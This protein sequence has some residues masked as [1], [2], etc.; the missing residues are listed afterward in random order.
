MPKAF[1]FDI[2][3]VIIAFD[4]ARTVS[5]LADQC[6]VGADEA[7]AK[8]GALT[9]ELE[10]GRILPEDFVSLASETIGYAG[11][12][13]FFRSAFEDIFEL[14]RPIVEFIEA[15]KAGDAEL[16]LLSN[17]NGIHAPFFEKTYPVFELFD[18]RIYSHEV[19]A[20]KPDARIYDIAIERLGLSPE[21]T[22]YVDDLP[23]NCEAGRRAG[24]ATI[25]YDMANHAG[26]LEAFERLG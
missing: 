14:N 12:P 24:F 5:K 6:A 21:S 16:H 2:G 10:L 8:V 11:E 4:F 26:F 15:Q 25:Q 18:G 20:M 1:L 13:E 3:N 23:G 22:V 9:P 17:T 7:L 19:G